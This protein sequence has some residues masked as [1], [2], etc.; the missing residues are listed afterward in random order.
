[1]KQTIMKTVGA[2]CLVYLIVCGY[3]WAA[4]ENLLFAT[5]P[6]P[7][8]HDYGFASSVEDV[9]Y[10][11]PDG[12]RLHGVRFNKGGPKGLV[13]YF[14]GNAGNNG[15]SERFVTPY[16]DHG[17][18]VLAYDY[19][20]FGKSRGDMSEEA[21]YA[22]ALAVFDAEQK[23]FSSE[24]I[25][26][27]AWSFGSTQAA[28]VAANREVGKVI[29]GTSPIF[30]TGGGFIIPLNEDETY[31]SGVFGPVRISRKAE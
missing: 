14:H 5:K 2:A 20:G 21:F 22:D 24:N 30:N 31:I 4:Q 19:R 23:G 26:L 12:A 11:R 1:M 17:Y 9:W 28:Y 7:L 13:I 6:V 25:L 16:V 8:D 18:E 3:I 15:Y 29:L 10:D 27:V